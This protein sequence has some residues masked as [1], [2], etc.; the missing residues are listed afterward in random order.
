MHIAITGMHVQ[1]HKYT[2]TQHAA[3]NRAALI[4][5]RF[6]RSAPEDLT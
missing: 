1:R 4:K 5:N 2:P 3:M 6:E